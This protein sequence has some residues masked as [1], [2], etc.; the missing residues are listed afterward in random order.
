MQHSVRTAEGDCEGTPLGVLEASAAG[1]AVVSTRHGGIKEAVVDG[2]TGFLVEEGDVKAMAQRMLEL[3]ESPA[4]AAAMGQKA[5]QHM[6][7]NYAMEKRVA[8]L[9]EIIE[10]AIE[11]RQE[12]A[13]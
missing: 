4:L 1:L 5:R 13:I 10:W 6:R 2:Q 3:A 7:A 9:A 8:A 12:Q 11:T